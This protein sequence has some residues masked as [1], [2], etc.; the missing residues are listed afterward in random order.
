MRIYEIEFSK[1]PE[2]Q[3][4]DQLRTKSKQ[5]SDALKIERNRQKMQNAQK[6]MQDLRTPKPKNPSPTI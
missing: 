3:R 1:T 4:L 6:A 2:Q 5:A